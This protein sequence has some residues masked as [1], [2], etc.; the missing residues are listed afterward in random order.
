MFSIFFIFELL[1]KEEI[2]AAQSKDHDMKEASMNS[3]SSVI[4]S[5]RWL[6]IEEQFHHLVFA[7]TISQLLNLPFQVD[8]LRYPEN[9][10]QP[11]DYF[12][13]K[14]Y[15]LT[16]SYENNFNRLRVD[17]ELTCKASDFFT[18]NSSKNILIRNYLDIAVL[19]GNKHFH[20]I[21]VSQYGSRA[22]Y[23][24][25]NQFILRERTKYNSTFLYGIDIT[26]F[27]SKKLKNLSDVSNIIQSFEKIFNDLNI[28]KDNYP[29][30]L[31]T[32]NE[33]K[34]LKKLK[35]KYPK[36]TFMLHGK[37]SFFNL[38]NCRTFIGTYRSEFSN[39]II[40][41]RA[42]GN[43]MIDY[44]DVKIEKINNEMPELIYNIL[45]ECEICADIYSYTLRVC[46]DNDAELAY[47]SNNFVHK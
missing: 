9:G 35:K 18:K 19:Y 3:K 24:I 34:L 44:G 20:N 12:N 6:S 15:L 38:I 25:A 5:M 39:A 33:P 42:E 40:Q 13:M 26:V 45:D 10:E 31:F 47:V 2:Q 4:I 46:G 41:S 36:C 16:K 11:Q 7:I 14:Q 27:K 28:H 23:Q 37:D 8:Y 32:S 43:N 21:L 22:V 1:S 17:K 30:M 29:D